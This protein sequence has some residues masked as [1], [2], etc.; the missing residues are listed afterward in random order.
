M[1]LGPTFPLIPGCF[2]GQRFFVVDHGVMRPGGGNIFHQGFHG[3]F[4]V[5]RQAGGA[6]SV[7]FQQFGIDA[8]AGTA[9]HA[10]QADVIF[11]QMPDVVHDPEGNGEHAGH[12][13][14]FRIFGIHITLDQTLPAAQVVVH[15]LQEIRMHQIIRIEHTDCVVLAFQTEQA[16][17]HPFHGKAFALPRFAET[18]IHNGAG[19]AGSFR[20]FIHAVIRHHEDVV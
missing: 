15:D 4:H 17:E 3:E 19:V 1:S 8:H 20:G 9:Q 14:I 11:G 6:P 13:G 18:F 16:V 10:G 2:E 7:L 12:P 5:F